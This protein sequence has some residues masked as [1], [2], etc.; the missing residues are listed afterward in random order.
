MVA[1][2]WNSPLDEQAAV[3]PESQLL[4]NLD[5]GLA[6][7]AL[8]RRRLTVSSWLVVSPTQT[9]IRHQAYR[10]AQNSRQ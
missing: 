9:I 3:E 4:A 1:Y 8:T 2:G 6:V 10:R 7:L 5:G